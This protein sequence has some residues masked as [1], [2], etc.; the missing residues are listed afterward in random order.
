MTRKRI[1]YLVFA[2]ATAILFTALIAWSATLG[3]AATT[4]EGTLLFEAEGDGTI[5]REYIVGQEFDPEGIYLRAGNETVPVSE[6]QISA[7][8][9]SAGNKTVTFTYVNG[10]NLTYEAKMDVTVYFV[11]G[12]RIASRPECIDVDAASGKLTMDEHFSLQAE[13]SSAPKDVSRFRIVG[14]N[15]VELSPE[16]YSA[17]ATADKDIEDLYSATLLAGNISYSFSFYNGYS[18]RSL[19]VASKN[20]VIPLK[21]RN[22][23][24]HSS[25]TLVVTENPSTYQSENSGKSAGY[26]VYTDADGAQQLLPF[27]YEFSAYTETFSSEGVE[28]SHTDGGYE[29]TVN[30]ETFAAD[31][32]VFQNGVVNGVIVE[33]GEFAFV[34]DSTNRVLDL[35]FD[36]EVGAGEQTPTLTLYVTQ[37]EFTMNTGSGKA[38]GFYV[39]TDRMGGRHVTP[40]FTQTWTWDYVPLSSSWQDVQLYGMTVVDYL[41]HQYNGD[42]TVECQAFTAGVGWTAR[43]V[44][45]AGFEQYRTAAYGTN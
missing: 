34:V 28:E 36:G 21:N 42:L 8:F 38:N 22:A 9:T 16:M 41:T 43:D 33:D 6:C 11:R 40:F 39:Y 29:V 20:N 3:N 14:K 10:D 25:L 32:D 45:R 2:I 19:F 31:A 4:Y 27:S 17:T 18:G 12:I 23:E 24:A 13:L 44:F 35:Q 26:Y 1:F 7:D 37:H 30:G 5:R 15:T